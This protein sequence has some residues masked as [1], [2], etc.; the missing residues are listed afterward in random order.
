MRKLV[1]VISNPADEHTVKVTAELTRLGAE[2]MVLCPEE[3]GQTAFYNWSLDNWSLDPSAARS[4]HWVDLPGARIDLDRVYSV[5][6]R[7]PRLAALS[8]YG[9]NPEDL[10]FARDEWRA[11]LEAAYALCCGEVGRD[12]PD[13]IAGD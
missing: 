7:R 10:E 3:L 11:A 2:P 13:Q 9:L 6:Y 1:L 8:R 12:R 5:W 4:A